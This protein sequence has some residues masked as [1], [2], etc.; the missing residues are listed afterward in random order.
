MDGGAGAPG[1]F[2]AARDR[3]LSYG[4]RALWFLDRV[5]PGNPAY[6]IAGAARIVGPVDAAALIRAASAL[7][8]RHPALGTTFHDT[9]DGP[10]QRTA[11]EPLPEILQEEVPALA[12]PALRRHLSE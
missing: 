4:Q 2:L 10:V 6:I 8:A 12:G 5:T 3:S 1:G 7:V 9:P 11:E